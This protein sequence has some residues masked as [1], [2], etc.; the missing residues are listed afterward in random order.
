MHADA[1]A[2]IY[3]LVRGGLKEVEEVE[4]LEEEK[5]RRREE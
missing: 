2:I 1:L 4:E 5:R 3:E